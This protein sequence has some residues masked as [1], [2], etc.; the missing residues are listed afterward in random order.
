MSSDY[1]R[2]ERALR[3]LEANLTA[4]PSLEDVARHVGLSTYH[5]QRMFQRWAGVTPK[6]FLQFITL[7]R[8]KQLL[9]DDRSTLASSLELG[10]SGQSRLHDLF[11]TIE[12]MTPG[13]YTSQRLELRWAVHETVFGDATF[14]ITE[15]GLCGISFDRPTTYLRSQWPYARLR[16]DH[17][18]TRPYA[19]EL[20]ARIRGQ[21]PKPLSLLLKGT[22][23]QLKVW[24]ALLHIPEG[25]CATYADIAQGVGMPSASRAVGS[26]IGANHIAY[27]VPCHR[28]IRATGALGEYA[29]GSERKRAILAL[30][31]A[32][33]L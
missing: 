22:P 29:W 15:R 7:V 5:F 17:I 24:E 6:S 32:R 13:D 19:N 14:V 11:V 10:L 20:D 23:F 4:Q 9:R 12:A 2:V 30:E 33:A 27:L 26:A 3:Y 16:E 18:A 25:Q 21:P 8:A 1:A 31:H 28:V